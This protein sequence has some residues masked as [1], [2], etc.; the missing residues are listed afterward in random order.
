M[1]MPTVLVTGGAGF[2]GSHTCRAPAGAG[3]DGCQLLVSE[4][5]TCGGARRPRNTRST[6]SR[7]TTGNRA[8]F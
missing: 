1:T 8:L 5:D 3:R 2:V 6:V 7:V 4:V